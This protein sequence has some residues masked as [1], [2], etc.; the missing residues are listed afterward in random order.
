[1]VEDKGQGS[2]DGE[3]QVEI[4]KIKR[5]RDRAMWE[6]LPMCRLLAVSLR[7]LLFAA[8]YQSLGGSS[9]QWHVHDQPYHASQGSGEARFNALPKCLAAAVCT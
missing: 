1:M 6:L 4:W 9:R 5:V 2:G 3:S 7:R 8:A